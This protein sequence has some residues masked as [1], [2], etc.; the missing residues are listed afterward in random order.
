MKPHAEAVAH[1]GRVFSKSWPS[2]DYPN[3][4][5]HQDHCA[6]MLRQKIMCDADV[7]IVTYD[8]HENENHPV[9]NFNTPHKC[10]NFSQVL[11]WSYRHQAETPDGLVHK[12][13]GAI[14]VPS[15]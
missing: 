4:G 15:P 9:A 5:V 6:D 7:G 1:L 8:W 14:V 3:D 10:R 12:P 11:E 13:E 2:E